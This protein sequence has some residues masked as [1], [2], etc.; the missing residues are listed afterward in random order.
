MDTIITPVWNEQSA[1]SIIFKVAL[2]LMLFYL[3][4][5][6][7]FNLPYSKFRRGGSINARIATF[8]IYFF[9]I[10][11]YIFTFVQAG[12][13]DSLYHRIL[14]GAFVFH[15]TKRCL[16]CLFLHSFSKPMGWPVIVM[17]GMAYS[18]IGSLAGDLHNR[19]TTL[20]MGQMMSGG[21]LLFVGLGIML[22]SEAVNFYHHLL[23][24][25]LRKPGDGN[26]SVPMGGLF[27][28]VAC[29]HYLAE[30]T[31]WLGY[32]IM[33]RYLDVYG[34][35][36]IFLCYLSARSRRTTKWY[37]E[38]VPGYPANRRSLIPGIF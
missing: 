23:L 28:Y 4:S 21:W 38:N 35:V 19:V 22:V 30:I 2:G 31:A 20:Q 11:V 34:I 10:P 13:P 1:F 12:S 33:S 3:E 5:S 18:S 25:R 32:A 9:P 15:F 27:Q 16:E 36:F 24:A 26:Y 29:P 7:K 8:L 17:V 6:G 14:F 37:A